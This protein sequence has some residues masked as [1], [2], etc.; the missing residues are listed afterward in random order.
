MA[1]VFL[2]GLSCACRLWRKC[3]VYPSAW[4]WPQRGESRRESCCTFDCIHYRLSFWP[5]VGLQ[6]FTIKFLSRYVGEAQTGPIN[7]NEK[8]TRQG[9]NRNRAY[10][11]RNQMQP[12]TPM[13]FEMT[14]TNPKE[15]PRFSSSS[16]STHCGSITCLLEVGEFTAELVTVV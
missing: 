4:A 7:K 1:S 16:V 5:T 10:R 15:Y 2:V 11:C 13:P 12:T 8:N 14:R 6:D 3:L 9:Q